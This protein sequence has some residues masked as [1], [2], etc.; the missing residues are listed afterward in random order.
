M[1]SGSAP[2]FTL[3][4]TTAGNQSQGNREF[5]ESAKLGNKSRSGE[6]LRRSW[7]LGVSR[8]TGG[9]GLTGGAGRARIWRVARL[10]TSALGGGVSAPHP[11]SAADSSS[12]F[13]EAPTPGPQSPEPQ[14]AGTV[15]YRCSA[16]RPEGPA[17]PCAGCARPEPVRGFVFAGMRGCCVSP[18]G[19]R[20][21]RAA[22]LAATPPGPAPGTFRASSPRAVAFV[23]RISIKLPG[24]S[25]LNNSTQKAS[26]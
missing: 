21:T 19:T 24:I 23:R 16:R 26:A 14:P 1:P 10:E 2:G 18:R 22:R 5:V 11:H 8:R 4:L 3:T 25:R 12:G 9:P 13:T 15:R 6:L 20:E 17:P 7:L